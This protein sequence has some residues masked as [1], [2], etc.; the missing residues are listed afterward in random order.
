MFFYSG[1]GLLVLQSYE[2]GDPL[3][4]TVWDCQHVKHG[5]YF[6]MGHVKWVIVGRGNAPGGVGWPWAI[7]G[8]LPF[9]SPPVAGR[10]LLPLPVSEF[11]RLPKTPIMG[12]LWGGRVTPLWEISHSRPPRYSFQALVS[13]S[14]PELRS[15][16]NFCDL[17]LVQMSPTLKWGKKRQNSVCLPWGSEGNA[18]RGIHRGPQGLPS[19]K[20]LST[21]GYRFGH[22]SRSKFF[23]SRPLAE[24]SRDWMTWFLAQRG[25]G[26][27]STRVPICR[28]NAMYVF[29]QFGFSF[30]P[31]IT[32]SQKNFPYIY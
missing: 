11:W 5:P 13:W 22:K 27:P 9:Q 3:G 7:L 21:S 14:A 17:N 4:R 23:L 15:N 8:P 12:S 25:R 26:R 10:Y 20:I 19:C 28:Q 2:N 6:D 29:Q 32:T 31:K 16:T 1:R 18:L 24:N 30:R